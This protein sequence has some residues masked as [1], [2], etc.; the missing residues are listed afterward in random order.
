[1]RCC[2][3]RM[4]AELMRRSISELTGNSTGFSLGVAMG[5]FT[6]TAVPTRSLADQTKP[7]QLDPPPGSQL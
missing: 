7:C 3:M 1:M 2:S 5:G 6:R 4:R